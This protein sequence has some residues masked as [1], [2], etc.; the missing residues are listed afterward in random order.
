MQAASGSWNLSRCKADVRL[1]YG[2]PGRLIL[3]G[4]YSDESLLEQNFKPDLIE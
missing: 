2:D 3:E 1:L 4:G